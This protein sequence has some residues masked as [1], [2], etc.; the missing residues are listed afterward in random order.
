MRKRAAAVVG[1][2]A[3]LAL[4]P[5]SCGAPGAPSRTTMAPPPSTAH[6]T[7]DGHPTRCWRVIRVAA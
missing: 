5:L 3:V 7:V 6:A 2:C 4:V 1:V